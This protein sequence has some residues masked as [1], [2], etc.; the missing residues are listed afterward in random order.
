MDKIDKLNKRMKVIVDAFDSWK[1]SGLDE[2]IM[3]IYLHDKTK[4][5]KRDIKSMLSNMEVFHKKLVTETLVE[6]L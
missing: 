1:K 6:A 4:L 2:E 3:V 5:S